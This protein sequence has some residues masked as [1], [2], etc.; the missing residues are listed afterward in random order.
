MTKKIA[1]LADGFKT[2]EK[3]E[4][5]GEVV[6]LSNG[7][8]VKVARWLNPE[9][10]KLMNSLRRPHLMSNG[11]PKSS[12]TDEVAVDIMA[13]ASAK[14]ILLGWKEKAEDDLEYDFETA[15]EY[16]QIKDL[17]A[18]IIDISQDRANFL[19]EAKAKA[20]KNS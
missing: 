3:K 16:F 20:A 9:H 4:I 8:F 18:E 1:S 7:W 5:E 10:A 11:R 19:A 15:K 6:Q 2:D 17:A 13:E 12:L 14:T